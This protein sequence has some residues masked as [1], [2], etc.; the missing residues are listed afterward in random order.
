M[1]SSLRVPVFLSYVWIS[2]Q[3]VTTD[4]FSGPCQNIVLCSQ[5][6]QWP[7]MAT[8]GHWQCR[9]TSTLDRLYYYFLSQTGKYA[10]LIY[11]Q[12]CLNDFEDGRLNWCCVCT[13]MGWVGLCWVGLCWCVLMGCAGVGCAGLVCVDGLCWAGVCWLAVVFTLGSYKCRAGW[14]CQE[15]PCL[16][17]KNIVARPKAKKTGVCFHVFILICICCAPMCVLV[18][19]C[20]KLFYF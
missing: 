6:M 16:V 4:F 14:A 19:L 15:S 13:G 7:S 17:F 12:N 11:R 5:C 20:L 10:R 18:Y 9:R 3:S 2:V 8:Q 1:A